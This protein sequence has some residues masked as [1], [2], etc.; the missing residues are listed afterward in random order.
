MMRQKNEEL[1]ESI[2]L[3]YINK[4]KVV[5]WEYRYKKI[6]ISVE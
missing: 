2:E 1:D 5:I 3:S 6:Y 4:E